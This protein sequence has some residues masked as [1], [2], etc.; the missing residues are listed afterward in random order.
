MTQD[1]FVTQKIVNKHSSGVSSGFQPL[2]GTWIKSSPHSRRILFH[3]FLN[4]VW[5]HFA[6]ISMLFHHNSN[7]LKTNS[8]NIFPSKMYY[9]CISTSQRWH[10]TKTLRESYWNQSSSKI[11]SN[12][13]KISFHLLTLALIAVEVLVVKINLYLTYNWD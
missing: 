6:S 11:L 10:W 2:S 1:G 3:G 13:W 12:F 7:S 5:F 8:Q 9:L 4:A